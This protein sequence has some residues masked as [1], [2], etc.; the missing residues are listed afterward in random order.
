MNKAFSLRTEDRQPKWRVFDAQGQI[1]G[2]LA[3][4]VAIALRG[5]DK[6]VFTPHQDAG[7][8]VVVKNCEKVLLTG[9]K[10]EQKLYRT[11]SGW[12]NK[13]FKERTVAQVLAK[14]PTALV[15][16]AVKGMLPKNALGRALF[17]KLKAVAGDHNPHVAQ[18][19]AV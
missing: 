8:F 6:V 17:R 14:H 2:R 19:G 12:R 16:H 11:H 3:T 5:K 9:K 13:G 18:T 15:E 10:V 1:L 7:D 4:A